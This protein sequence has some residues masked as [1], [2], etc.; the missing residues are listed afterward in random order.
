MTGPIFF[1]ELVLGFQTSNI[2]HQKFS[3]WAGGINF[4][5]FAIVLSAGSFWRRILLMA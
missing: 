4:L 5:G 1:L 3:Y 2:A